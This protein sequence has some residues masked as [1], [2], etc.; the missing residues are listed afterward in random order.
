[1]RPKSVSDVARSNV[2]HRPCS[3]VRSVRETSSGVS[4][5]SGNSAQRSSKYGLMIGASSVSASLKRMEQVTVRQM[6][7]HLPHGPAA[8][9]V[10]CTQLRVVQPGNG[11]LELVRCRL[12]HG[13]A[14]PGG[15]GDAARGNKRADGVAGVVHMPSLQ[16]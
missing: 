11:S 2:V 7:N 12:Q 13:P 14:L 3:A 15:S 10:G 8:L 5:E 16:V 6:M 1:M 4:R 9:T